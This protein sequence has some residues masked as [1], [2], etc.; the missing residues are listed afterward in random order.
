MFS[1]CSVRV[2]ID[3]AI[4]GAVCDSSISYCC[5]FQALS[6]EQSVSRIGYASFVVSS[7][8]FVDSNI[9]KVFN[10]NVIVF[11]WRRFPMEMNHLLL[12]TCGF[13][14]SVVLKIV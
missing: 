2:I 5:R 11:L 9:K 12:N 10:R 6:S 1:P 13:A 4:S 7:R 3:C 8:A 14:L